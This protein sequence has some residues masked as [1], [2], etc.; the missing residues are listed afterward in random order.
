[1]TGLVLVVSVVVC[2]T[3]NG[4]G[5]LIFKYKVQDNYLHLFGMFII[6]QFCNYYDMHFH[7]DFEVLEPLDN[8]AASILCRSWSNVL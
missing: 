6:F 5:E 2:N 1:V 8:S 4:D 7:K 3:R